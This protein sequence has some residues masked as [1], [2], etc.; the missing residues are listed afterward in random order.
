[1][2]KIH[3]AVMEIL[4]DVGVAF[5]E[6]D[7][8]EIFKEHGFKVEGSTVFFN[9]DQVMKAVGTVPSEYTVYA[10]NP[11]KNVKVGG[12]NFAL[13][14]GWGAPFIIDNDGEQRV[15]LM[16]DYD[17]FCK[18]VHTSKYLDMNGF[19]MV[20][21]SDIP[22]ERVHLDMMLSN[23]LLT[24]KACMGSPND[25][26]KALDSIEM[27]SILWGGRENIINK[28][29]LPSK[30]N[31]VSP[32]IYS[33][34]MCGALIEYAKIGQPLEFPDL[35]LT[36][37]SS[38]ITLA[39]A[40]TVMMA[41][42]LAGVV[43]AQLINPGMPCVIG[44]NSCATDMR[45][46]GMALGGPE[47]VRIVDMIAQLGRFYGIPTKAGGSLT[48]S[49]FPDMQAGV[50]SAL[51]MYTAIAAG[52]HFM[53]QACGILA[54]FNAMSFEKFILDEELCGMIKKLVIPVEVNDETIGMDQI[55]RAGIGG[56][57]I[58]FPET[59]K[60]CRTE[61]FSPELATRGSYDHWKT[62]GKK[63]AHEKAGEALVKRL[64]AY[65]KPDIDPAI[66][67]DLRAFVQQ[68]AN[69]IVG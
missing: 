63:K 34:E 52:A 16:A 37:T 60:K 53:N 58:T 14:P 35:I 43:L 33:E 36:G 46:G 42:D 5:H 11:E 10:R 49:F 59:F 22:P 9:E 55:K 39:G 48:D 12:N 62:N 50:E 15:P 25:R 18:L 40:A 61:L 6:P 47:A 64:E 44:G 21:P 66:E 67:K 13:L 8:L 51:S 4:H 32:L 65:K 54:G 29:V 45:T 30:I 2:N 7:A 27:A 68:R 28:P 69:A 31:P 24:D 57:Y 1:M 41:E 20:M 3:D 17:K 23:M 38:P 26:T 56:A 19:L